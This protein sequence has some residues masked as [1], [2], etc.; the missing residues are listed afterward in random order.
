MNMSFM[1]AAISNIPYEVLAVLN[2]LLLILM[3]V[4]S[5]ATIVV[6]LM[7]KSVEANIGAISGN[8]TDTYMGKNKGKSKE[9][10]LKIATIVMG[11]LLLIISL[12]YFIIQIFA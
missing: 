11:A 5:I 12:A 9:A 6:V 4:M 10:K 3:T 7:Q 2:P 1:L 8:E